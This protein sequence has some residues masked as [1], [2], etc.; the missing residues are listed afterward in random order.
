MCLPL[1][2]TPADKNPELT[3]MPVIDDLIEGAHLVN[4]YR[5]KVTIGRLARYYGAIVPEGRTEGIVF[6]QQTT[7]IESHFRISDAKGARHFMT[8]SEFG[9]LAVAARTI[10]PNDSMA[11]GSML[12]TYANQKT[13]DKLAENGLVCEPVM[14]DPRIPPVDRNAEREIV[15]RLDDY[16][17]V[18]LVYNRQNSGVLEAGFPFVR[19]VD[20]T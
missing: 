20:L 1:G 11:E 3:G 14:G 8:P 18:A 9:Y 19:P 6:P 4:G 13:Q 2:R 16:E 15:G 17:P 12:V 7:T 5:E 10:L